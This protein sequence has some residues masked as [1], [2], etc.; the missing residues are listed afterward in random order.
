[1]KR[2][3]LAA[4]L[5]ALL[6]IAPACSEAEAATVA[7]TY[8]V[9][10]DATVKAMDLPADQAD[11]AKKMLGTMITELKADMSYTSSMEMLGKKM[12]VKGTWE[13]K[14]GTV[15]FTQTHADGKEEKATSTGT[16]KDGRLTV[17]S[18]GNKMVFK[19]AE[20]K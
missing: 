5:G 11:A 3:S 19:K 13:V 14:D 15:T 4:A 2:I 8:N 20:A 9:D 18:E 6:I 1:M 12:S 7:G 10:A 17:D 16:I